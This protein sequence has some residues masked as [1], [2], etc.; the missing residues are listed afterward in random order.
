MKNI[1]VVSAHP[2]DAIFGCGG[3]LALHA[4]RGD[5]IQV[6]VFGDGWTS[7]VKSFAKGMEMI[8]LGPLEES[9]KNALGAIGI[10][11]VKHCRLPDNRL[12]DVPLLDLVKLVEE[13][14]TRF[15]PDVVYTNSPHDL[16]MDQQRTCKAVVT[17]FRPLPGDKPADLLAFESPSSTEWNALDAG[18]RPTVHVDIDTTLGLK[19]NAAAMLPSEVRKW[20][21]PRSP[22]GIEHLARYRGTCAGIEAAEAFILMRSIRTCATI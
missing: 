18:F 17:A 3:T 2:G 15:S 10:S 11:R 22:E 20:P 13:A 5:N 19:K 12:D 4:Q 8:D 6:I 9:E 16:N 1:L 7:R 21:H 14:K